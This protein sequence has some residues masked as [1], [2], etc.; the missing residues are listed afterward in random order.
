M[1][2][3]EEVRQDFEIEKGGVSRPSRSK[4]SDEF[5]SSSRF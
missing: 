3:R 1:E 5:F 2:T 4:N